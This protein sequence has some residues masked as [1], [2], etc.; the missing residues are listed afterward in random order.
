M[1]NERLKSFGGIAIEYED[2]KTAATSEREAT[3]PSTAELIAAWSSAALRPS[4]L[5][6]DTIAA[7]ERLKRQ[8]EAFG[9][10]ETLFLDMFNAW[11]NDQDAKV[12]KMVRA[13]IDPRINYPADI[14]KIAEAIKGA[15]P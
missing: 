1:S 2:E 13:L 10:M 8:D 14:S 3:K 4:K 7:L 12:G 9:A 15:K 11:D 5:V 6:R